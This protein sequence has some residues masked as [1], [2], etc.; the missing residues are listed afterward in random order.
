[1]IW[2]EL[3]ERIFNSEHSRIGQEVQSHFLS[4]RWNP[5]IDRIFYRRGE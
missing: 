5:P 4:L 1:M 2:V 3:V